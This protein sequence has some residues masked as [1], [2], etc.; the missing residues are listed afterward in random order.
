[1]SPPL[2]QI[3]GG[4]N[5]DQKQ[6]QRGWRTLMH[7]KTHPPPGGCHLGRG[8]ARSPL[9]KSQIEGRMYY[10]QIIRIPR[11]GISPSSPGGSRIPPGGI[12]GVLYMYPRSRAF[13]EEGCRIPPAE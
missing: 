12:R 1:M 6:A 8:D 2:C 13:F 10:T 11:M 9:K 4:A 5:S 3:I 7:L